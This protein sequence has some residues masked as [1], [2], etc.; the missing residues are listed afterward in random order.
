MRWP[1]RR[2]ATSEPSPATPTDG[3]GQDRPARRDASAPDLAAPSPLPVA[4]HRHLRAAPEIGG[5][6]ALDMQLV[7]PEPGPSRPSRGLET[8]I[9]AA[10]A[11]ARAE[12]P[13]PEAP[14]PRP[15]SSPGERR[16][17]A[18]SRR[19]GLGPAYHG[20]L[21]EAMRA[22]R[23]RVEPVPEGVREVIQQVT[24]IDVGD[25]MVHRGPAVSADARA[26][27]AQAF[28]REREVYVGDEVGGL[29]SAQ[30]RATVAHE[31]THVAQQIA[32]TIVP[33]EHT[34]AGQAHEAEAR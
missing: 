16:N 30:A 4:E 13:E 1:L 21:P 23:M 3:L 29:D 18:D 25:K 15:Q 2:R 26:M 10:I 34:P 8:A 28:T 7:M 27:G 24:G 22:E 17:L 33:E 14:G 20:S 12:Q 9:D 32:T 5:P 11:G 6:A 19:M 31:M